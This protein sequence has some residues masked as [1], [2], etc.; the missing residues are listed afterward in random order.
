MVLYRK[1]RPQ[2][3]DDLAGQLQV[4]KLLTESLKTGKLSHAYLF[5]GPRGTG[6][7]STARILA[8][9]VNCTE[10]NPPCNKCVTCLSITDGS[11]LDL[12]EIDAASNR[13]I[14]DIRSLRENVKLSPSSSKKK[15]YIIDEVHMLTTEAFNGLLKTLEE[16]PEHTLF[17]MATT[18]A[19]KIPQTIISRSTRVDFKL[20][21]SVDLKETLKKIAEAEKIKI[22]EGALDLLVKQADG[23][24]RDGVKLLDQ[25]SSIE[26]EIKAETL[27]NILQTSDFESTTDLVFSL[28]RKDGAE[29]IGLVSKQLERGINPKNIILS[30]MEIARYLILINSGVG[31]IVKEEVGSTR[32]EKLNDLAGRFSNKDLARLLD[33]CQNAYEKQKI[34]SIQSLPLELAIVEM[35]DK[36]QVQ[37]VEV[38][39]IENNVP[40]VEE[41]KI[42][43]KQVATLEDTIEPQPISAVVPS[44]ELIK[45]QEKWTF[46]LE[47]I[48]QDNFSLEALLRSAKLVDCSGG[49]VMIE[50]PY[51]FHQKIL[52]QPKAR[53]LIEAVLSD[54]LGQPIRVATLL[55]TRP[56]R[57]EDIA[58]VELAA[59]D[60][61]ISLASEIFQG[62]LVD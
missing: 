54:V 43:T 18:E 29:A 55:G 34:T 49:V 10:A 26:G 59:D 6:K 56:A 35:C 17:I 31:V 2:T 15:V 48:R 4:K 30:L 41:S 7:T 52:E 1:Y 14:D 25:L 3:L 33:L 40:L 38:R 21:S 62:K 32:I 58:N 53:S 5:V 45:L 24:F 44:S 50:V 51:T 22:D 23:S 8:K 16:P 39:K 9:M 27:S 12:I 28:S 37:I 60:E 11:N 36:E 47:T 61:V 42:E 19:S 13:G 57:I 20:A 46:V